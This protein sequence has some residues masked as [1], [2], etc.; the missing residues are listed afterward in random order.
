MFKTKYP[1]LFDCVVEEIK[2]ETYWNVV[3]KL[4]N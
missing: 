3:V 4:K 1:D 2:R